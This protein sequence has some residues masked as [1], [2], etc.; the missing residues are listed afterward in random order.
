MP[1][2]ALNY[3]FWPRSCYEHVASLDNIFGLTKL[4]DLK[5][6]NFNN[7]T[8]LPTWMPNMFWWLRSLSL[9]ECVSLKWLCC[10]AFL[11]LV[12][13]KLHG[14]SRLVEFLEVERG[15][16]PK[17]QTLNLTHCK[18]LESLP[19]SLGVHTCLKKLHVF[20]C[21]D[22]LQYSRRTNCERSLIWRRFRIVW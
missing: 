7:F 14:C 11:G 10:G 8:T 9:S 1:F 18:S 3:V 19:L 6:W 20:G 21:V 12:E 2:L 15:A 13:L 5:L 4:E 16:M 22:N 17:L